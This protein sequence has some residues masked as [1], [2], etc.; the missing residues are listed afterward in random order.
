[1]LMLPETLR[2]F[3][4]REPT[5]MRLGFNGLAALAHSCSPNT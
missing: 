3:L 1:M 5:D 2:I 4:R